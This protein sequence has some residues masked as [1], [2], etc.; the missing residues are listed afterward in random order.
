MASHIAKVLS[1]GDSLYVAQNV[2]KKT[3]QT[4]TI[5]FNFLDT[6]LKLQRGSINLILFLLIIFGPFEGSYV[7]PIFILLESQFRFTA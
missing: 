6:I 3:E 4:Q 7:F 1:K 5:I 2:S